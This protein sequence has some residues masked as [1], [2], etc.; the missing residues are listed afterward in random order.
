[1]RIIFYIILG[2]CA[3]QSCRATQ[4]LVAQPALVHCSPESLLTKDIVLYEKYQSVLKTLAGIPESTELTQCIEEFR[5]LTAW[6]GKKNARRPKSFVKRVKL[7]RN[8]IAESTEIPDAVK[9][10]A[11]EVLHGIAKKRVV[12]SRGAKWGIGLGSAVVAAALLSYLLIVCRRG[13]KRSFFRSLHLI[14]AIDT[15]NLC[16]ARD[17]IQQGADVNQE[18][19]VN[20]WSYPLHQA[21]ACG[22]L[23]FAEL[24]I[25]RGANVN[26]IDRLGRTPLCLA[27]LNNK[28]NEA[29]LLLK[30][31]AMARFT[32]PEWEALQKDQEICDLLRAKK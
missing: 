1:M 18:L 9:Y 24:V 28:L 26:A 6:A 8:V 23:D 2:L 12:L 19:T 11:L 29:R 21:V 27:V 25:E 15:N 7:L 10:D 4:E 5:N 22:K 31:G 14:D 30:C 20:N 3:M 16:R 17:L 32:F 13:Q